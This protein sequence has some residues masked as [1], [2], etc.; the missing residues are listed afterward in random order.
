MRYIE[1]KV[2]IMTFV[3]L[4]LYFS[5]ANVVADPVVENIITDPTSPAPLST[6]TVTANIDGGDITNVNLSVGE[7]NR[8]VGVCYVYHEIPMTEKTEGQY[9]A[10][11]T[12]EKSKASYIS[13]TFD[14][15][16]DGETKRLEND[17]WDVD[18]SIESGNG[19]TTN[20]GDGNSTPGF[21]IIYFLIA[22]SIGLL[23]HRN[24]RS[25]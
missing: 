6:I 8:T 4:G 2:L 11:V 18:L 16:Y 25:R 9:T 7:C 14:I 23:L 24:K 17:S 12:L 19:D 10:E 13:F 20:G 15:T 5:S 1:K 3:V 22:V 21:E